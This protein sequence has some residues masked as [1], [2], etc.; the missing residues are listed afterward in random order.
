MIILS[1]FLYLNSV[2]LGLSVVVVLIDDEFVVMAFAVVCSFSLSFYWGGRVEGLEVGGVILY[3]LYNVIIYIYIYIYRYIYIYIYG[4][5]LSFF[6]SSIY[7]PTIHYVVL[8]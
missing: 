2:K 5:S 3:K 6:N 8:I 1:L 4:Y 7:F